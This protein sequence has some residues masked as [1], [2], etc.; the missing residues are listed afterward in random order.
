MSVCVG[1][2]MGEV[3]GAGGGEG[4]ANSSLFPI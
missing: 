3:S 4:G 2:L 1:W